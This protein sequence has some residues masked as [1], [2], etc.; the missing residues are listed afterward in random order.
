MAKSPALAAVVSEQPSKVDV[1]VEIVEKAAAHR[2]TK[3]TP[4]LNDLVDLVRMVK[5]ASR[6]LRYENVKE[7]IEVENA[8]IMALA[9][10]VGVTL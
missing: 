8:T 7:R 9:K 1:L 6:L 4:S 2:F 5:T 3:R 10:K